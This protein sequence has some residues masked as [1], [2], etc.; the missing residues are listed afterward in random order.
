MKK[1]AIL[2]SLIISLSAQDNIAPTI[3][4]ATTS[5]IKIPVVITL[6]GG[7]SAVGI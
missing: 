7:A 3:T 4:I 6:A 5:P 2:F 1:I